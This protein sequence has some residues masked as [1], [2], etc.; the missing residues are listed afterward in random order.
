MVGLIEP[1]DRSGKIHLTD[2]GRR[3]AD[4]D[5]SQ[6]EF[7]AIT[8][9]T[10]KLPNPHVQRKSECQQWAHNGLSLYPLRLLLAIILE[11]SRRATDQGYITPRE[12]VKIIIPLSGC[13]ADLQD[14]INFIQWF[15]RGEISLAGWPDCCPK[16]NDSR[17]ARE[18]LLFLSNYGYLNLISHG[19][20]ET[21]QYFLNQ[22]IED[23]IR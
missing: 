20:R 6:S 23:E 4:H 5:I 12:L 22:I 21:E 16:P 10:Y 9:Q 19:N 18:Y 7:A 1:E 3:V 8:V 17:F 2:F 15:R 11:L 13:K 14:Y